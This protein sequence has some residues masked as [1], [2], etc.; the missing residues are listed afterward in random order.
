MGKLTERQLEIAFITVFSVLIFI[1]FYTLISMNGV[2]LGNDPAVHLEKAQI[3]LQTGKIPL[4]NLGWTP[5]LYELLLT[6]LIS[7]SGATGIGQQIFLVKALAVI[8][9]WLLFL[10]VY[11]IGRKFFNKKIGAVAAVLL[12]M[13]FPIYEANAWGGYTTVLGITFILLVFLYLT[14]AIEQFGYL[15]VTFFA[16]FALVLSHQLAAF[17]GVIMLLP[18]LLYMLI[19]SKGAYL[20]VVVALMLGGGIA[21]FLYYFQAMVPYLG[22]VIEYVFF[23]EKSY[24]TQIPAASFN[25][26]L[27]NF[28]FIF[29]FALSGIFISYYLL[30]RQ[31]NLIFYAILMLSFF[32]PLFFA[33]SYIF[34]LYMPFQWFIYYLTP[35]MAI[36]AAVSVVFIEEKFI[37][38]YAKNKKSFRKNWLTIAAVSLIVLMCLMLV[39]R[40][41]VVYGKIMQAS[42]FYSTTD[43]K[44]YDAGVWLE[45]NYPGDA[46]VVD[47][48]IPGFWFSIFSGKTVIAQ[49]SA[50]EG[51]NDIAESVL[52]LS[53]SIQDP[54]TLV[55]AYEA[56]GDV[57]EENYVSINQ[58]WYQ[59]SDSS[60][61]GDFISF[62]QNGTNYKF[63][64]SD[65]SMEISFDEQSY[66]AKVEFL[67]SNDYVELTETMFV[68]N[69]SYPINVSW[70]VTPLNN[71]I[72]NVT[73]YLT[74]YFDPQFDFD[75]A[76]IPQLMNWVNPWNVSSKTTEG[77]EWAVVSFTSSDLKDNYI[78]LYDDKNQIAFAFNF[79]DLPDWGNIGALAS[80]QIDAVR[81]QYQFNQINVNQ[82]VTRQY[83]VLTLSKNSFPTLQ[84]NELESLFNF[85]P[86]QFTV[87]T[88]DFKDYI[89]EN[90]IGFIVY[91]KNQL[92]SN[93][94]SCPFLEL[95]Y[96]N[97]RYDI[98]KILSNY[99]QTQT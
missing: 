34:G 78:G 43:I 74:T 97:D 76:Q 26:F 52:S 91:D 57:D 2:V 99:N 53:Y 18:I 98:F 88:S 7:F 32:V 55:K 47:T 84:P 35:P 89:A 45:Q 39:G 79:T 36:F 59:V 28:G 85:K 22:L 33:E 64:L 41:N 20:K 17:L 37:V 24:A 66:P 29:I 93:M 82:T 48:Q 49:T 42:V 81:F 62:T 86:G 31:K 92:N 68:Q 75:E 14:L 9:D 3:F 67:Y 27:V 63:A 19:K 10:S 16:A 65:L 56:N 60:T 13:C 8:I 1:I 4:V 77:T 58:I 50:G 44:A 38:Y 90:N 71:D 61:A 94:V 40:S 95:I 6:M 70:A 30:K 96:S 5:P 51:T 15:V 54:Q 21:F 87:S 69:D 80:R 11:L 83:Q 23:A 72:S 46:T 73:L 12:L 25:S